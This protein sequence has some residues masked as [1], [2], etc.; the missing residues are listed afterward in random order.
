MDFLYGTS[1]LVDT[2]SAYETLLTDALRGDATLFTRSDEVEA[3][4]EIIDPILD[5]WREMP[6]PT[7]PN[8]EAGSWGPREAD[9][10]IERD[11][12]EWRRL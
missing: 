2:P 4:W 3:A 12:R 11:G 6:P 8:Y 5:V 1:F 7:F 10:L 9:Q